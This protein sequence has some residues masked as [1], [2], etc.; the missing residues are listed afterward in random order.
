MET[1]NS[2]GLFNSIVNTYNKT[3]CIVKSYGR[4]PR[5]L[6]IQDY[7]G[8]SISL[9]PTES[10]Y[11]WALWFPRDVVFCMDEEL[12]TKLELAWKDQRSDEL[13]RLWSLARPWQ[14]SGQLL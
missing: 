12:F 6:Y 7:D 13:E 1:K 10:D 11:P 14:P 2:N 8:C 9:K 3:V 4:L 5:R